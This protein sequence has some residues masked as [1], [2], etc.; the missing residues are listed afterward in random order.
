MM[1]LEQWGALIAIVVT[2]ITAALGV[3]RYMLANH[4][5]VCSQR[6]ENLLTA[7]RESNKVQDDRH[8]EN[9]DRQKDTN[10]AVTATNAKLDQILILMAQPKQGNH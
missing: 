7:H 10:Q 8:K 5:K 4:E 2:I 3:F 6:Y 9:L 1:T